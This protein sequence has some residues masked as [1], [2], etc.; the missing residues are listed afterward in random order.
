[1]PSKIS[2]STVR[3]LFARHANARCSNPLKIS[4]QP[5]IAVTATPAKAGMNTA[6]APAAIISPL[7]AIDQVTARLLSLVDE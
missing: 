6:T 5:T 1:M 3:A 4:S 7:S 2:Q